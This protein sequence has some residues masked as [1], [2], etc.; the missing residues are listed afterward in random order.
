MKPDHRERH[1]WARTHEWIVAL[2]EVQ[3]DVE[4][5]GNPQT[6]HESE[7]KNQFE[8]KI[9]VLETQLAQE[10]VDGK[11]RL[12]AASQS[13]QKQLNDQKL[14]DEQKLKK[15]QMEMQVKLQETES[16]LLKTQ[17]I[18]DER[19]E[20]DRKLKEAEEAKLR[21]EKEREEALKKKQEAY[22]QQQKEKAKREQEEAAQ[23]AAL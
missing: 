23:M 14:T 15:Y 12:T 6:K 8:S 17:T 2:A 9:K 3:I 20:A 10:K 1:H 22:A 5:V 13:F 18:L 11:S 16:K 21:L 19:L 4:Q 7:A